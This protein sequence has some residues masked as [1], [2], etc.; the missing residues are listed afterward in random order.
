LAKNIVETAQTFIADGV[1]EQFGQNEDPA[2]FMIMA[3]RL[4]DPKR[5]ICLKMYA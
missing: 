5:V 3:N 2:E 1:K 4:C